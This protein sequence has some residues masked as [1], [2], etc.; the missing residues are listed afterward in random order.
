MGFAQSTIQE[1]EYFWGTTDPGAGSGTVMLVF[2]GAFDEAIEAVM[3][4]G[5][6]PS[7]GIN[8]FNIR[9]KDGSGNWGRLYKRTVYQY[10]NS[11]YRDA[12]LVQ[13]EYFWG[14]TD[15]GAGSGTVMLVFDG[16]FDEAIEAV[17]GS[18]TLPSSG[19]NLFNI[20]VKDGSGNWG[21]LYKRTVYQYD[22]SIYRDANLVQAEYFWGTTDP[23]VG[24]G[25]AL[26]AEDGSF[27]ESVETIVDQYNNTFSTDTNLLNIR[28]KDGLGNWGRL[29]KRTLV[30]HSTIDSVQIVNSINDTICLGNSTTLNAISTSASHFVWSSGD[31]LNNLTVS[32]TTTTTYYVVATHVNG[33][34]DTSFYTVFVESATYNSILSSHDTICN[35]NLVTLSLNN[36]NAI[37]WSTGS[38]ASSITINPINDTIVYADFSS[39][40]GCV[41]SDTVSIVVNNTS[42]GSEMITAC[43]SYTWIDGNTYTSSSNN[44]THTLTNAVGCDS[45]VTLDLTINNS[46]NNTLATNHTTDF[47][48]GVNGA[49]WSYSGGY[50]GNYCGV[51]S[52]NNSLYFTQAGSRYISST[53]LT[54]QGTSSVSFYLQY[55]S[56]FNLCE[57][58]DSGEEVQLQ[59]SFN[60]STWYTITTY[61]L[62]QYQT[63]GYVYINTPIPSSAYSANTYLRITQNSN[64][65]SGY[66]QWSIDDLTLDITSGDVP[67]IH[68]CNSYTWINGITYINDNNTDTYTLTNSVGCDSIVGLDLVIHQ[69]QNVVDVQSACNSYTWSDGV[70]YTTNNTTASQLLSNIGGCDSLVSLNLT[71]HTTDTTTD[72]LTGCGSYTWINGITYVAN[73]NTATYTLQNIHG[74]DSL[75]NLNLTISNNSYGTEV[76][77]ACDSYTWI[78][79]NTYTSS[80]NGATHIL[81][82][83]FGCDSVVTLDLTINNSSTN[84]INYC[85]A[86]A[87]LSCVSSNQV[88]IGTSAGSNNSTGWPAPFGNYYK[89]ARHQFLYKASELHAMGIYGGKITNIAWQTLYS[90]SSTSTFYDYTI[91]MGCTQLNSLSS[92][93]ETGLFTIYQ[94]KTFVVNLGWNQLDF[95]TAY[96]WDGVSNLVIEICYDNLNYNYTNN[97]STPYENTPFNSS[98]FYYS[99]VNY[100]CSSISA[101]SVSTNRPITKFNFCSSSFYPPVTACDQYTWI[102]GQ[103]YFA[104]NNSATHILTNSVGCDSIVGLN[105]TIGQS[106]FVVD[107]QLACNSYTWI[108]GNT[109]TSNNNTATHI[110]T[111]AA[112]CD[113]I[114]QLDLTI[115]N[116][117]NTID[118]I[119]ACDSYTWVNGQTYTSSNNSATYTLTNLGGC[120]SIVSLDLT[121]NYSSTTNQNIT[122]CNSYTWINGVTYTSS[123]NTA[124]YTTTNISGCDSIIYLDLTINQLQADIINNAPNLVALPANAVYQWLDC[125]N[126]YAAINGETNQTFFA[127]SNGSYAVEVTHNNC[128][129]TSLCESIGNVIVFENSFE[130]V[131]LL[132]PNPTMNS[133]HLDFG[134]QVKGLEL[135]ILD[136]NGK[137]IYFSSYTDIIDI[138]VDISYIER[139][140]YTLHLIA[141]DPESHAILKLIKM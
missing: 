28:V 12:N 99:D 9:V 85:G 138:E 103:T 57:T 86:N 16:A 23:G 128:V 140:V 47:E 136:F 120:D 19:I 67:V 59:Y 17:M 134:N 45:I 96:E 107:Q 82:N 60:G 52:G 122:A 30:F 102:N 4:S 62:G 101:S 79:G 141:E 137:V 20:R 97:W 3:G 106:D 25:I 132:Y 119:T 24:N 5:T 21:R 87:D 33:Q 69:P 80:T 65:G 73:N 10:D 78:D 110:L 29:Y 49:Y 70:T 139:G 55:G 74:C 6:L 46:S 118:Q 39:I 13:A 41:Y 35:N 26:L 72:V 108:D 135:Q 126:G 116:V 66:D 129:D 42:Y 54:I 43:D 133:F 15:P 92:S 34:V 114:I 63:G 44:I 64:S 31:T 124:T 95:D 89:N 115:F 81:S 111:N 100:A 11:I 7:S 93:W 125:N 37:S 68:A 123:N 56:S 53:G 36:A 90:N 130:K 14:T 51:N 83:S 40:N 58:V 8:L 1:A 121:I 117:N 104:N 27:N 2:D 32:P 77:S 98:N 94:P 76:V 127:T 50:I 113:S 38:S 112:G 48:S 22:N 105:L 75:V 91:K 109:Y 71:I 131:P 61:S 84:A 88:T 18:G